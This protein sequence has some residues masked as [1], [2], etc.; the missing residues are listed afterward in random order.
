MSV[1]DGKKIKKKRDELCVIPF[2]HK[3]ATRVLSTMR[4]HPELC[5][6][7]YMTRKCPFIQYL[8]GK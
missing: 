2:G 7:C 3:E 5:E 1:W 6:K 8:W 4:T